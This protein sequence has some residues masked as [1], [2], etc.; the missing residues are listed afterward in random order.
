MLRAGAGSKSQPHPHSTILLVGQ[1]LKTGGVV[2][3]TVI[4]WLHV[5]F[6]QQ[7]DTCQN[8]VEVAEHV[9]RA[10]LDAPVQMRRETESLRASAGHPVTQLWYARQGIITPEEFD[11]R[12]ARAQ[13]TAPASEIPTEPPASPSPAST[14]IAERAS[15]RPARP[16]AARAAGTTQSDPYP[17]WQWPFFAIDAHPKCP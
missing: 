2:S 17:Q 9:V 7:S 13:Q 8:R 4:V 11:A 3:T 1:L 10:I 15:R 5:R 16:R 6:V 12:V 14:T